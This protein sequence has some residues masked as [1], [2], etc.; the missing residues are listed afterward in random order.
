MIL[1]PIVILLVVYNY[2]LARYTIKWRRLEKSLLLIL[3]IGFLTYYLLIL[4]SF[5][6]LDYGLEMVFKY[7]YNESALH[8]RMYA[9]LYSYHIYIM[10]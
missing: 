10:L 5:I 2:V 6:G 4:Y 3:F 8:E 9:F 1:I 7:L